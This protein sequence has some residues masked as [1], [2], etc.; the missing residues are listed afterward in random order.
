MGINELRQEV[1]RRQRAATAK[2]NRLKRKGVN[3]SGTEHDIRRESANVSRYNSKQ[4]Q[5]Y[6]GQLNNFVS[7]SNSFVG[8]SEG[9]PIS[10]KAWT[11]YKKAENAY[12]SKASQHYED[13]K[14]IFI[15]EAGKTVEGF[16]TTMRRKRERGK[17][18]VPRPLEA[19]S[20]RESYEVV[21]E[22]RLE[23]LRKD[24][25]R[26]ASP[27]YL[28]SQLKKQRRQMLDSVAVYGDPY[29]TQL[30]KDL[31]NEQLDTLWNYT[32]APR[33]LFA[34]YHFMQLLATGKADEAQANIH[35]DD[36]YEAEK[37]ITWAYNITPRGNG[38]K[39]R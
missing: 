12:L 1:L 25:E 19:F 5:T 36:S 4:L 18:G 31:S 28:P 15:P 24:L 35:E 14:D 9:T 37:W 23:K 10:R 34:G 11:A 32:D 16:D 21:N 17:G 33:D 27:D 38:K 39:R 2:V 6:L 13:V 8:G 3:V 26:K 20:T 29:L 7:R 30:A 22:K